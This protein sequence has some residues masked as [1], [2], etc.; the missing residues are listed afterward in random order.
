MT[1]LWLLKKDENL[2]GRDEEVISRLRK[3]EEERKRMPRDGHQHSFMRG[4]K[5]GYDGR[6]PGNERWREESEEQSIVE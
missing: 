1:F 2:G 5:G 3:L 4:L 6:E